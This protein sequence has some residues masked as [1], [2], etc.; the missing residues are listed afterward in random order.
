LKFEVKVFAISYQID[1]SM[2]NAN[3]YTTKQINQNYI[4]QVSWKFP[5]K[6]ILKEREDIFF[7]ESDKEI[8]PHHRI[9]CVK[10]LEELYSPV[11]F[12]IA[13]SGVIRPLIPATSGQ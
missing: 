5:L 2:E 4:E 3:Q 7:R 1:S 9:H 6:D 10:R 8:P 13:Y 11:S 12:Q